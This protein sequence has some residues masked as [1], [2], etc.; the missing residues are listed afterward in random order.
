[1]GEKRERTEVGGRQSEVGVLYSVRSVDRTRVL[2]HVIT[3]KV[4]DCVRELGGDALEDTVSC[5]GRGEG[6][7]GRRRGPRSE[8]AR[9]FFC[10]SFL[11]ILC[12]LPASLASIV[13]RGI[14]SSGAH[15]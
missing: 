7:E 2:G 9:I 6:I 15:A 11:W 10:S 3:R 5:R 1:M 12:P 14:K 8:G 13:L 4:Y